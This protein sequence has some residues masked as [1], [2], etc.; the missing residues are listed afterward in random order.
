MTQE[1]ATV[2][3]YF[4]YSECEALTKLRGSIS[5]CEAAAK[6]FLKRLV[7]AERASPAE[8]AAVHEA[9]GTKGVSGANK[10][11]W[12]SGASARNGAIGEGPSK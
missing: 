12:A 8:G 4:E 9:G 11:S 2:S 5:V 10:A 1:V 6:F 7:G 3:R